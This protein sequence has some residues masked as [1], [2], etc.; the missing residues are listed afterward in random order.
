M[1][2][3]EALVKEKTN[4]DLSYISKLKLGMSNNMYLLTNH[5]EKYTFRVPGK[6]ANLFVNRTD[7][8]NNLNSIK[9]L[10]INSRVLYFDAELGYKLSAYIEGISLGQVTNLYLKKVS[11][12]LHDL[13]KHPL[14]K[15]DYNMLIRLN[16][17][18]T[19]NKKENPKYNKLKEDFIY[20]FKDYIDAPYV[21]S[22]NDAQRNNFILASEDNKLYLLDWEFA[23][24]NDELYDIA[25][26]GNE[27]FSH[28]LKLLDVYLGHKAGSDEIKHLALLRMFQCLQ[29]YNVACY[30]D[31]TGLSEELEVDFNKVSEYFIK[32]AE[33]LLNKYIC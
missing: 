6:N 32:L 29:W 17:Y 30:K 15:K 18:E 11:N 24:N 33:E 14:L 10:N 5:K 12:L 3:I 20:Y 19:L 26:F 1:Q 8:E 2:E 25:C 4:L 7:E 21:C 28:A 9:D 16:Y 22:H 23:G 27:N 13:H 31:K